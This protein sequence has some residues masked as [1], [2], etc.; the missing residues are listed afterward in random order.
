MVPASLTAEWLTERL[1]HAGRLKGGAR[2]VAVIEDGERTTILS[3][4]RR[5]RVEY[6]GHAR[7]AP[8]HLLLKAPRTDAAVS[9]IEQGRKPAAIWWTT[10]SGPCWPTRTCAAMTCSTDVVPLARAPRWALPVT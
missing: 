9:L 5:F 7:T 2:A 10:W 4:L 8:A 1:S 6:A 3:T